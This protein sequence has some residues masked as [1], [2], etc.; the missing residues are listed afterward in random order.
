MSSTR[1]TRFVQISRAI[2]ICAISGSALALV[3]CE[4]PKDNPIQPSAPP[5]P[6]TELYGAELG[7]AHLVLPERPVPVSHGMM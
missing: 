1:Y 4:R 6:A 3:A 2:C 5:R 7:R